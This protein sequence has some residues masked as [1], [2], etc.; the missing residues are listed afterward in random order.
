MR[1]RDC[2]LLPLNKLSFGPE[3]VFARAWHFFPSCSESSAFPL[4]SQLLQTCLLFDSVSKRKILT[5]LRVSFLSCPP[6]AGPGSSAGSRAHCAPGSSGPAAIQGSSYKTHTLLSL[7]VPRSSSKALILWTLQLGPVEISG[8][9]AGWGEV[10]VPS[11]HTAFLV[12][13]LV[14]VPRRMGLARIPNGNSP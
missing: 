9:P 8:T 10:E 6:R 3:L 11:C 13:C 5:L 1:R 4:K 12:D 2:L 7:P 14:P